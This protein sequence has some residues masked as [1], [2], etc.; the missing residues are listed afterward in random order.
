MAMIEPRT[1]NLR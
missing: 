1:T